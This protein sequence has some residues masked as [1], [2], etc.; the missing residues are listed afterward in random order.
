MLKWLQD[1][2]LQL[3]SGRKIRLYIPEMDWAE[4]IKAIGPT[5]SIRHLLSSVLSGD[6]VAAVPADPSKAL[7]QVIQKSLEIPEDEITMDVP[8][9]SYGLDS[10][11]ASR[12]SFS[13]EKDFGLSITQI[14]L[15]SNITTADLLNRLSV[16]ALKDIDFT[17]NGLQ[18]IINTMKDTLR[19]FY[20]DYTKDLSTP[21]NLP[22]ARG[23]SVLLTGATGTLGSHILFEIIQAED[24][25]TVHVLI[26]RNNSSTLETLLETAL[27]RER[28]PLSIMASQKLRLHDF[29]VG[30]ASLS[31]SPESIDEV[32][33]SIISFALAD[34]ELQ[35][36]SCHLL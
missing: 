18:Q 15:L 27:K 7:V 5:D 33:C 24:V 35:Y 12:L 3:F 22:S 25:E 32:S 10:L 6:S 8:L 29:S 14:Q 2:M 11:V 20:A 30:Q 4:L 17:E 13:L 36:F 26:R 21:G 1:G 9:T 19:H 23:K 16:Q 28:L 34:L 31:L